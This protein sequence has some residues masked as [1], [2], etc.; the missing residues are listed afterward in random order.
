MKTA[1][2]KN[3]V[4]REKLRKRCKKWQNNVKNATR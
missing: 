2:D 4:T 1:Q 3:N